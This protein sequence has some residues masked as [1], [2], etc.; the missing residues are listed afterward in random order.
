[1]YREKRPRIFITGIPTA[2][3]S[4]LAK[5]LLRTIGG[6]YLEIDNLRMELARD[7]RYR[8]WI[9]F[10]V[11]Q[12]ELSYY[13]DNDYEAQWQN[14]VRQSEQ[15]WPALLASI[16]RYENS[17]I[18]LKSRIATLARNPLNRAS[19]IIFEGVNLLPH[20]TA[21]DLSF[22][23]FVIAGKSYE[24]TISRNMRQ[25]R[26]GKTEEL[27]RMEA[28]AFWYGERPHYIAEAER[29]GYRIFETADEA[30]PVIMNMLEIM[31]RQETSVGFSKLR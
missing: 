16:R 22:P 10:Y 14:L 28:N 31:C 4:Y 5:K 8:Q 12:D 15:I 18:P 3:K 21:K 24:D 26:W 11:D 30:F 27:Q 13:R 9:N 17:D 29:Y 7:P 1:M 2:G 6:T 19:P 20:L 25:P 23:G